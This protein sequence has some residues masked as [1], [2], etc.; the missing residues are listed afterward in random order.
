MSF[1]YPEF[2]FALAAISV[3]IVIHLFNFRRFKKVYFSD[4][5]FLKD[6][7]IETKSRNKLKN[8]LVL[9]S[10]ILAVTFLVVAFAKP[11]IP[12]GNNA[13]AT[14]NSIVVYIDNSF[15]MSAEGEAGNLLEEAKAKAIEVGS[16]YANGAELHLLTNDFSAAQFRDLSFEEFKNEVA[17]VQSSP[18]VRNFDDVVSRASSV[19]DALAPSTLYY[20]SDLQSKTSTPRESSADSLLGIQAARLRQRLGVGCRS[21]DQRHTKHPGCD[22]PIWFA[23][24]IME[25]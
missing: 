14:S 6:V 17:S 10:R 5:R 21:G 2:L 11:V 22:I 18:Q 16:A 13:T 23:S 12:T 20:V 4:I 9:L 8:L 19:F 24:N 15:S 25:T 3:P 1:A 7:E